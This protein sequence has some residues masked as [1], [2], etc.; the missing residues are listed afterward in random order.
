MGAI[1]IFTTECP[2]SRHFSP[3]RITVSTVGIVPEMIRFQKESKANL[4]VSLHATTDERRSQ[5]MPMNRRYNISHLINVL[6]K[7]YPKEAQR[8]VFIEY[9]LLDGINDSFDD[10]KRLL[11]LTRNI[12]CIINLIEFNPN[13]ISLFR[14]ARKDRAE[15]FQVRASLIMA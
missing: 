3:R 6:E 14:K 12:K 9:I 15:N 5:L 8:S 2:S 13:K 7:L 4:A 11:E 1:K 10:A